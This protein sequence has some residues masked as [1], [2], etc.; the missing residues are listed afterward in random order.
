MERSAL[1]KTGQGNAVGCDWEGC[2]SRRGNDGKE[3]VMIRRK[4][5]RREGPGL[6]SVLNR[7]GPWGIEGARKGG[8]GGTRAGDVGKG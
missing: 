5:L 6:V 1:K 2:L 3:S 7:D 8:H 4:T